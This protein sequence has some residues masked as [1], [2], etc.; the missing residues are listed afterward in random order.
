MKTCNQLI[1]NAMKKTITSF[2][3]YI[4]LETSIRFDIS[5]LSS[6]YKSENLD[7]AVEY[8]NLVYNADRTY[9]L[10]ITSSGPNRKQKI[11]SLDVYYEEEFDFNRVFL[12]ASKIKSVI[13]DIPVTLV[14]AV[15][16]REEY[17]TV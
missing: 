16:G 4:E 13:H 1:I 10:L 8:I 9:A 2:L 12:S 5:T 17:F 3:K 14:H 15:E 7:G 6:T 11:G